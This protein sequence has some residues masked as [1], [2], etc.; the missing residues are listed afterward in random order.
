M[1]R[2]SADL[3]VGVVVGGFSQ[4]FFFFGGKLHSCCLST[5]KPKKVQVR[6]S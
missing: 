4:P 3:V 5:K 2:V 1:S 6:S